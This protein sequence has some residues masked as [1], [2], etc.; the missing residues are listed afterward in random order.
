[1]P[2]WAIV[3]LVLLVAFLLF[4]GA[5]MLLTLGWYDN[6]LRRFSFDRD[7]LPQLDAPVWRALGWTN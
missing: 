2:T 7:P 1:V 4:D 6:V 5:R 3:L